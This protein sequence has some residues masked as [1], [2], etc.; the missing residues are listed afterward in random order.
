MAPT[1]KGTGGARA[2]SPYYKWLG[3]GGTASGKT[4]NKKLT[5]L[6]NI[7]K[8]LTKTTNCAYRA[9]KVEGH[10]QKSVSG[11]LH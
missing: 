1:P 6:L 8:A 11:A 4:A 7:T 2:S 9:K 3:T 10:D 5:K